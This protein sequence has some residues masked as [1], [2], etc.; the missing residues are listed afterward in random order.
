VSLYNSTI[1]DNNSSQ[2]GWQTAVTF[3]N[4]AYWSGLRAGTVLIIWHRRKDI[5]GTVDHPQDIIKGDG[6]LELWANDPIYFTGGDFG[7]APAF[8][9]NS[10]N[11]AG[12]GDLVQLRDG[13]SANIHALG[14]IAAP[15]STFGPIVGPKLNH[16]QTL[17]SF[18]AVFVCPGSNIN[19]YGTLPPLSGTTWTAKAANP[20][21]TKGLPNQCAASSTANSDYWRSIRQPSWTTP[22]LTATYTAPNVDLSWNA[23]IDPLPAD[24]T[25]GYMIVRN[26]SNTFIAPNDGY[27]YTVGESIGTASVIAIIPSSQTLTYTD[28]YTINCGD[29]LFYQVYAYRFGTDNMNGNNFNVAREEPTTKQISPWL[30]WACLT[31]RS[32]PV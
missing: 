1:R 10:L 20:N 12:G 5:T 14:H 32:L 19:E 31:R 29:T 17:A 21:I 26:T 11:I 25:Q 6:Y 18:E 3:S 23:A 8:N 27:T 22:T 28:T 9:G 2:T 24:G 13:G 7:P 4:A 16:A 15:G 30:Q